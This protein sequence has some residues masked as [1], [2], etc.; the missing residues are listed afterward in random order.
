LPGELTSQILLFCCS[1]LVLG[2]L[3]VL[4]VYYLS[5]SLNTWK[6]H[7]KSGGGAIKEYKRKH[8]NFVKLRKFIM[9]G[10]FFTEDV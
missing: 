5:H 8:E 1:C 10:K 4:A 2:A 6:N 9:G 7:T 3:D